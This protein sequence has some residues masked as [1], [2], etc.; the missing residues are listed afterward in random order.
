MVKINKDF[1]RVSIFIVL[2]I[3]ILFKEY[4]T[5]I[6]IDKNNYTKKENKK[7]IKKIKRKN[8]KTISG[9]IIDSCRNG[10]IAGSVSGCITG[11]VLG[12]VTGGTIFGVSS[13][14]VT[15]INYDSNSDD[16]DSDDEILE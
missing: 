15:Y 4:Y 8:K 9:K 10:V 13:G 1:F 3:I 16:T 6:R 11:G 12:A 7:L 2:L 14:I 5:D